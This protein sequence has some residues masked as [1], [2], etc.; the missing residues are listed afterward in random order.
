MLSESSYFN[1]TQANNFFYGP[2]VPFSL[3]TTGHPGPAAQARYGQLVNGQ[4]NQVG[5][6]R[7]NQCCDF[8]DIISMLWYIYTRFH[9]LLASLVSDP[10]SKF[11]DRVRKHL[12]NPRRRTERQVS[13][14]PAGGHLSWSR[15]GGG[16]GSLLFQ[17]GFQDREFGKGPIQSAA[18]H[19]AGV[20]QWMVS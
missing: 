12:R 2:P 7:N 1:I 8:C 4:R 6:P 18:G 19:P 17:Q 13:A 20:L 9:S 10:S 15:R 3:C 5:L 16:N 11:K 14:V